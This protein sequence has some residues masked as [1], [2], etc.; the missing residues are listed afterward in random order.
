MR[1][2]EAHVF[3]EKKLEQIED[4]QNVCNTNDLQK[5]AQNFIRKRLE[6]KRQ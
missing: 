2:S 3:V 4:F 5:Y 1:K 6:K